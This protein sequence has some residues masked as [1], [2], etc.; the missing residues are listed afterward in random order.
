M[1][2][3]KLD[4]MAK[5]CKAL[6]HPVR[7]NI[8]HILA[9]QDEYYCGDIVSLVGMAQSTVSHHLKILKDSG[10]VETEERGTFVCYRVQREKMKELSVFLLS[11]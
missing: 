11:F 1:M 2:E 9:R 4:E 5:A 6:G 7:L 8:L 10:L 3:R